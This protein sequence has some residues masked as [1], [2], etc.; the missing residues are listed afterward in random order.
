MKKIANRKPLLMMRTRGL[1][2]P[3]VQRGKKAATVGA[4]SGVKAVGNYIVYK[5][6]NP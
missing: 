3:G 6:N 5:I 2:G 1:V 4:R